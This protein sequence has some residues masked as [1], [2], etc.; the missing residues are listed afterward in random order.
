MSAELKQDGTLE[1]TIRR[2][3]PFP[4]DMVFEAWLKKEH[5]AK[6][7][8]P[9]PDINLNLTEIDP[10]NGG[11]YRFGFEER[12]CSDNTSYVHGEFL[13]ILKPERLVFSWIWEEPLPEAGV[14]TLVTVDFT[15]VSEGT[16]ITLLH[17]KFMDEES[18]ERHRDGWAGTLDKMECYFQGNNDE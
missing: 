14:Y 18:C 5:L 3:F 6:W 16:E 11:K 7:M 15:E 2:K 4:K 1:L 10:Q 12:G 9:T 17:Q 8:G 13:E